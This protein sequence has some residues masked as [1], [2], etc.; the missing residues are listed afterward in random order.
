MTD[1]VN[2]LPV[3]MNNFMNSESLRTCNECGTVMEK[4]R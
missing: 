3:V 1:I 2:Q 4:P